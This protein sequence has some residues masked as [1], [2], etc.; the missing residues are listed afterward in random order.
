MV[1]TESAEDD[2][3][4]TLGDTLGPLADFGIP[5]YP[6]EERETVAVDPEIGREAVSDKGK[7][8]VGADAKRFRGTTLEFEGIG[9]GFEEGGFTDGGERPVPPP[10]EGVLSFFGEGCD[11]PPIGDVVCGGEMA[12]E[13]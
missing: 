2:E 4:L 13:T 7:F 10:K 12:E 5:E 9:V 6:R 8:E 3:A 11:S 1:G